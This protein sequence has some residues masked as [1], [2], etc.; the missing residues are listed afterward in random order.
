MLDKAL[1]DFEHNL[2]PNQVVKLSNDKSIQLEDREE[3]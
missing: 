3:V 2:E 1:D